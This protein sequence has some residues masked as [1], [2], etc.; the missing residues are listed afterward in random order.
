MS[1]D[2][3]EEWRTDDLALAAFLRYQ[4]EDDFIQFEWDGSSCFCV[5]RHSDELVR[6]AGNFMGGNAT[7][8]PVRYNLIYAQVR[9]DMRKSRPGIP[10]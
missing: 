7:V 4:D 8:D 6:D 2:E 1:D 3:I 10:A 5:F 9:N